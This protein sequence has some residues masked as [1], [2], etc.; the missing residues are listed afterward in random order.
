MGSSYFGVYLWYMGWLDF[1]DP[2][3]IVKGIDEI[4]QAIGRAVDNLGETAEK[5]E[6]TAGIVEKK[7]A[8]GGGADPATATKIPVNDQT[9]E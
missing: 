7:V 5:V 2:D 6:N 9:D 1:L 8:P 3:A 4:E